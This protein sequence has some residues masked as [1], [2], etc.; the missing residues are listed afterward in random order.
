MAA[1]DGRTIGLRLDGSAPFAY[2]PNGYP[3]REPD[4]DSHGNIVERQ[5]DGHAERDPDGDGYS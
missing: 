3:E 1:A 5:T 4:A 2:Q